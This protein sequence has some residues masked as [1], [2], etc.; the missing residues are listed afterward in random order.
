MEQI[1]QADELYDFL[2][3]DANRIAS[4]YAQIFKGRLSSLEKTATERRRAAYGTG[5]QRYALSA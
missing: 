2:Y 5:P 1:E 4:Y 3:K